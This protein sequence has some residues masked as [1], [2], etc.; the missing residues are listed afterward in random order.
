MKRLFLT[1]ALALSA[2]VIV[3]PASSAGA[4]TLH[5]SFK[6]DFAF[7]NFRSV[8]PSGCVF[9]DVA[10]F[11]IDGRVKQPNGTFVASDAFVE[12]VQ[13]D[14][15]TST[16]LFVDE[17]VAFLAPDEFLVNGQLKTATLNATIEL[18]EGELVDVSITWTGTRR[19]V[20]DTGHSHIKTPGFKVNSH[21]NGLRRQAT[22]S[23]TVTHG[24]TNFTP[25]PAVFAELSSLT[26]GEVQ[27]IH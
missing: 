16:N 12:I 3:T 24:T 22:A 15:C 27:I 25:E 5:F 21:S 14:E 2:L 26:Q 18:I 6:G 4:E 7:A 11:V 17:G 23:G 8:D 20:R 1:M 13:R 19:A 10:V 9:T